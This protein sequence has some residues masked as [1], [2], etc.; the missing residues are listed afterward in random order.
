[1]TS[2][3]QKMHWNQELN[4]SGFWFVSSNYNFLATLQYFMAKT[5]WTEVAQAYP[6]PKKNDAAQRYFL[7][8]TRRLVVISG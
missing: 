1:M 3:I 6:R 2:P 8:V 4:L 5:Q 7:K